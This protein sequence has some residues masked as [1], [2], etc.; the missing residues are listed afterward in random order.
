MAR[1]K[2]NK[3]SGNAFDKYEFVR[4]ELRAE[5]KKIAKVWIDENTTE[6]GSLLHDAVA[7]DYKFSLSFSSEH[8]TFTACLTGKE[9]HP[10]NSF[11]TLTARH[12]DWTVAAMT[13]LYKAKVMFKDGLWVTADIDEDDGWA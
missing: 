11:K 7:S 1:K 4:C 12:K 5:D 2:S 8:D 3:G 10:Y 6:L 13:L 9:D